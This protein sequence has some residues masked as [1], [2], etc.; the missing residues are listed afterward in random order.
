MTGLKLKQLLNQHHIKQTEFA[1]FL[2]K[3]PR[4][5][6][7]YTETDEELPIELQAAAEKFLRERT[8]IDLAKTANQHAIL[9]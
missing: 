8:G 7:R 9:Q 1:R 5:V 3:S 4:Q 2:E 6:L